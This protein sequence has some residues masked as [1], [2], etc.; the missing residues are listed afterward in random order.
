MNTNHYYIRYGCAITLYDNHVSERERLTPK[1]LRFSIEKAVSSFRI[2]A[3]E[4]FSPGS[5]ARFS[6]VKRKDGNTKNGIFL[7]P[8]IVTKDMH[9]Q[10]V[11][12]KA[13][14]F[15]EIDYLGKDNEREGLLKKDN[16]S[17]SNIPI[18]GEF[19]TFGEKDTGR[20]SAKISVEEQTYG[21]ITTLTTLKPALQVGKDNFCIIPDIPL[22]QMVDFITLL[23]KMQITHLSG[24]AMLGNIDNKGIPHRPKIFRGNF[25]NSPKSDRMG[26]IAL[27]GA[28]GEF[29][30]HAEFSTLAQKVLDSLKGST[31]YLITYANAIPFTFHHYIIDLAK[32]GKLHSIVDSL[33]YSR[34]YKK[35]KRVY[36]DTDY[37]RFDFFANRFLQSFNK[38]A[39]DDFFSSRVEYPNQIKILFQMFFTKME[40]LKTDVIASAQVLGSWLN[41]VAYFAAKEEADSRISPGNIFEEKAKFLVMMES[42]IYAAKRGDALIAQILILAGRLS[43][44]EAPKEA[45]LFM[46]KTITGEIDL[47]VAKNLLIAYMRIRREEKQRD[48]NSVK[49]DDAIPSDINIDDLTNT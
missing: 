9:A 2:Q 41:Q 19:L 27:L 4:P 46:E 17:M 31:L 47:S 35:E 37:D 3:Q 38:A 21:L 18:S 13:S 28:I 16:V 1:E 6:F 12:T 25:P 36:G 29:A 26:A 48:L 34:L 45:L 15:L 49:N 11:W 39:F 20:G 30:K 42:S 44:N 32:E 43:K 33:F 24:E 7:S 22:N 23:D 40:K 14:K 10:K 8:H 5:K